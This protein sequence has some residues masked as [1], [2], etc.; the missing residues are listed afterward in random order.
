MFTALPYPFFKIQ[1]QSVSMTLRSEAEMAIQ[2][3]S[4]YHVRISKWVPCRASRLMSVNSPYSRNAVPVIIGLVDS[5]PNVTFMV[6]AKKF[7]FGLITSNYF[8]PEVLRQASVLVH[9][10]QV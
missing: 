9:M 3:P 7:I 2:E 1:Y 4:L 10:L 6:V 5:S 8:V